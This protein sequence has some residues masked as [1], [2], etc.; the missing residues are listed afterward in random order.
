MLKIV[1]DTNVLIDAMDDHFS[2]GAKIMAKITNNEI[3]AVASDKIVKEYRLIIDRLIKNTEDRELLE[4]FIAK[5]EIVNPSKKLDIIP[6]DKEDEK[7]VETA[8]EASVDY[9]I[10]SDEHLLHLG[11]YKGIKI[12]KPKN[13][14]LKIEKNN[15]DKEY[16]K[17]VFDDLF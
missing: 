16:W 10:S 15:K 11:N 2:L 3:L 1:I 14:L 9:I 7:F 12:L 6:E 4:N 13:F 5:L 8:I 17:M